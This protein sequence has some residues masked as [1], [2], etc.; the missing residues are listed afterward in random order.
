MSVRRREN[1]KFEVRWR[2]GGRRFSRT[3]DRHRDAARFDVELRRR[4]QLG[5]VGMTENEVTL[6]EFVEEWW[7]VHVIPNL[8]TSTRKSYRHTWAKH[9]LPKLGAYRIGELTPKVIARYRAELLADGV[10][11]Q[12][13]SRA[14]SVLQ[15]ILT[16]A[17]TE[18]LIAANPVAK[19]KKPVRTVTRRVE[20]WPPLAVEQLRARLTIGHA[21]LIS[22]LAYAGLRPGEALALSWA[23][24]GKRSLRITRS[25]SAGQEKRTKTGAGRS[26]RLLEPL[27]EDLAAWKKATTRP[28]G[29]VFPRP[30]GAPWKEDDWRN[31]RHRYFQHFA[32]KI[33]RPNARP[34]D[35]RHSFVSL[36]IAEGRTVI[37]VAAQAG[38][39]PETCLR[40][41]A[42][43]F[44]ELDPGERI[45]A[46]DL[47]RKARRDA[48]GRSEDADGTE[49]DA[50]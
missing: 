2:Q 10:G 33:G 46:E 4:L 32:T 9:V 20:P 18:E 44:A 17:V 19:I 50:A 41:Y 43:L 48:G 40:Y 16:M 27:A 39:S 28:G 35:L 13:V 36:L 25:I 24:V 29:L 38:H 23:D 42:H 34:Y 22:V 21:T 12:T 1:G 37:D 8:A 14:L 7:R 11:E 15:S 30:D 6:A 47:I 26:V 3:F 45:S 5:G 49:A 31:W